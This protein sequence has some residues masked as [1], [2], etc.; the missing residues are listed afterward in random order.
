[1][2]LRDIWK[3]LCTWRSTGEEGAGVYVHVCVCV[4]GFTVEAWLEYL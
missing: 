4:E 1:M 2:R 3:T